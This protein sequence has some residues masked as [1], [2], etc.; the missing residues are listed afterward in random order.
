[1]T[2]SLRPTAELSIEQIELVKKAAAYE[3]ASLSPNTLRTYASLCKKFQTWCETN[4]FSF[5]PTS[6]ETI[7]LYLA[8]LGEKSSFSTINSTIA[9]IQASHEKA[10]AAI[11]GDRSLYLRVK[12][13]IRRTHAGNQTLRQARGITVFSLWGVCRKLGS[14]LKDVRDKAVIT[15]TFFGAFRRSEVVSLDVEHVK[16][17]DKG[18]TISLL[19]SKTSDTKQDVY[20][21]FAKDP[22]ICPVIALKSWI[23]G[24]KIEKSA[25]FRSFLKGDKI[26]ARRLGGETVSDIIKIHFGEEYSGH[27][28]RRGLTTASADRGTPIHIIKQHTR[29]KSAD[30]ILRYVDAATGF[31]NS[32]VSVLGL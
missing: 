9:A 3:S 4:Q 18:A 29:H 21:A 2:L 12:K 28:A 20:I 32:S 13:G 25:L 1:M 27:S 17:T 22:D 5:L 8:S 31:E 26:S 15:L 6:A 10:G 7:A 19:Q 16:F 14:S 30:M 24:A 23:Y 11:D